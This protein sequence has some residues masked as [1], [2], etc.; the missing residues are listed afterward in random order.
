MGKGKGKG[1]ESW[2]ISQGEVAEHMAQRNR[3]WMLSCACIHRFGA[4][5]G[6]PSPVASWLAEQNQAGQALGNTSPR[7]LLLSQ[8]VASGRW[9][10][11]TWAFQKGAPESRQGWLP[12]SLVSYSQ[13]WGSYSCSRAPT[14]LACASLNRFWV[15]KRFQPG[16]RG[17]HRAIDDWTLCM[18][19][20]PPGCASLGKLDTMGFILFLV[21]SETEGGLTRIA[22]HLEL[23]PCYLTQTGSVAFDD[24]GREGLE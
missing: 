5:G 19:L 17:I 12:L 4:H 3:S 15:P 7:D 14:T 11:W 9:G 18:R 1:E 22:G 13:L 6:S 20:Q 8:Q 24:C 23:R 16:A 10:P 2:L 21:A